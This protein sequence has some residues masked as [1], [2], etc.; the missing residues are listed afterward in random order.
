MGSFGW[1]GNHISH[2][3]YPVRSQRTNSS[4]PIVE[5]LNALLCVT[6]TSA[7]KEEAEC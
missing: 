5:G 1:Q 7:D 3:L 4:E 2:P 6:V